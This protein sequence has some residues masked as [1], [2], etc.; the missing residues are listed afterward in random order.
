MID[1]T[2]RRLISEM[3]FGFEAGKGLSEEDRAAAQAAVTDRVRA[4]LIAYGCTIADDINRLGCTGVAK[5]C[6]APVDPVAAI[7]ALRIDL[8][9]GGVGLPCFVPPTRFCLGH[10]TIGGLEDKQTP[11]HSSY[12]SAISRALTPEEEAKVAATDRVRRMKRT[13]AEEFIAGRSAAEA[14]EAVRGTDAAEPDDNARLDALLREVEAKLQCAS[15][16]PWKC[17]EHAKTDWA[18]RHCVAQAI[19]EGALTPTY[20][21]E[22]SGGAEDARTLI[23]TATQD[24]VQA[25]LNEMDTAGATQ[26]HLFVR[27]A[28]FTRKLSRD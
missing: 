6:P 25:W 18:C 5:M 1:M 23:Q 8:A 11:Y 3:Q 4:A 26:T 27:V 28:T 9:G 10:N 24:D 14:E 19:V 12:V 16:P 22:A 20:Y 17:E 7:E 2:D 15:L 21:G 13:D